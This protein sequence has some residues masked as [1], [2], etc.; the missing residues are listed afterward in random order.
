[1]NT[2][3][4]RRIVFQGFAS[5]LGGAF[6]PTVFAAASKSCRLTERDI[7]GPFYRFGAPFQTKLAGPN[8]PGE[9]LIITGKVYSSDCR[10]RLPNTLIEVWQANQAGLY[11]TDK[12]G[13][14]TEHGDFHLR[15]MMLTDQQGNYEFETIMPGRYPVPPN[16][17]GLEKYA[18]LTRPAHIH[19]RVAE[20]LH[21]PLT[22]QLYSR[23]IR[24][25]PKIP[26]QVA[27]HR[28]RSVSNRMGSSCAALSTLYS[29]GASRKCSEKTVL[30][31]QNSDRSSTWRLTSCHS[32][33]MDLQHSVTVLNSCRTYGVGSRRMSP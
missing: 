1:M 27:S 12:P 6:I 11:D 25:S 32:G 10:S 26:G 14:F 3:L 2:D 4:P 28:W 31:G 22:T 19:F 5:L 21:V 33:P 9:R 23:R 30:I 18:G 29:P 15:G 8:E 17:P 7:I 20:S 16:F 24:L 13:N